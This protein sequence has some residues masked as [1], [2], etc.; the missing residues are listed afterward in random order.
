MNQ[1]KTE[2]DILN[3][4]LI[5][6]QCAV[7]CILLV[8]CSRNGD[9]KPA[10][11]LTS[12]VAIEKISDSKAEGQ[13]LLVRKEKNAYVFTVRSYFNCEKELE[14]PYLT[15]INNKRATL[16]ITQKTSSLGFNT[17]YECPKNVVIKVSGRLNKGDTIYVLNNREVLG[18]VLLQE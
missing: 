14:P 12:G 15:L 16:V 18:H 3:R 13:L 4:I 17:T 7:I 2:S 5:F 8:S 10:F 9:E 1:L 6:C 11:T